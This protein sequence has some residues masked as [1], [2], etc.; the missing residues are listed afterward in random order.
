MRAL[1][2]ITIILGLVGMLASAAMIQ[3]A[4]MNQRQ[5]ELSRKYT[6]EVCAKLPVPADNMYCWKHI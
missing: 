4:Q 3:N 5:N 6:K 2:T 1:F